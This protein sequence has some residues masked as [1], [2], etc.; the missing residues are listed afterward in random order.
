MTD[1]INVQLSLHKVVKINTMQFVNNLNNKL[2]E[3]NFT[4][5]ILKENN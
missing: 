3:R 5:G 1:A 4:L 2:T